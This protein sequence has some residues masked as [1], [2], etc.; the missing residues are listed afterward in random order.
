LGYGFCLN[1]R[2]RKRPHNFSSYV[3]LK[4]RFI[5][6]KL[7]TYEEAAKKQVWKDAM[8]EEYQSIMKMCGKGFETRREV[9]GD[10]QM[11]LQDQ[12]CCRHR[13]VQS[14]ICG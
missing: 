14:D 11:N 10:F 8:M 2:E 3:A 5:D 12:A 9:N 7:S 4:R 6:S 13:E 1:S